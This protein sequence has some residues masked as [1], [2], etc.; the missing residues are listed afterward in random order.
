[1][2]LTHPNGTAAAPALTASDG[3]AVPRQIRVLDQEGNQVATY[4]GQEGAVP[5]SASTKSASPSPS[6]E[7]V[8]RE[9]IAD[10]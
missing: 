4:I 7:V 3:T 1:M 2:E 10:G 6:A 5:E 9:V 8:V